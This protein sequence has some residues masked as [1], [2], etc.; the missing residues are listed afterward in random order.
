VKATALRAGTASTS[1]MSAPL[2][3]PEAFVAVRFPASV[4]T[5]IDENDP[6]VVLNAPSC[7]WSDVCRKP[8]LSCWSSVPTISVPSWARVVK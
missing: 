3:S 7:R 2:G 4:R 5:S 1:A 6:A 8:A